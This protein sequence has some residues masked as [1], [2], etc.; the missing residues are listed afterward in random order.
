[1]GEAES[2]V[3]II[4]DDPLYRESSERLVRSVGFSVQSFQSARVMARIRRPGKIFQV[5]APRLV[6]MAEALV[7]ASQGP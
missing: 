1:M 3:F 4:D 2:I 7:I 5:W 6:R